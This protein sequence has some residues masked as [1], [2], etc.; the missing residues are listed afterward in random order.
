[1]N[2]KDHHTTRELQRLYRK[3][4]N[5]RLARRIQGIYLAS[6]GLTC[7]QITTVTGSARRTIQQWL[8][9]YNKQGIKGLKEKPRSGQPAKLSRKEQRKLCQR[10]EAGPMPKDG[11]SVLNGPAIRR[12]LE[13]EF[14]VLYSRQGLYDLLHRLG[15]SCIY[16]RPKHENADLEAQEQFKKTSQKCW[17]KSN[18]NIR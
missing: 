8:Y 4:K 10:I 5:A 13:S 1:M 3:E 11:V 2:V 16:P 6:K 18:Q 7:S 9:K 14:G 17:I 15:Y 12:I